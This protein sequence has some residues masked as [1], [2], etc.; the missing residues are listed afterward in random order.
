MEILVLLK[1][2]LH[3]EHFLKFRTLEE[4]FI[5]IYS[6]KKVFSRLTLKVVTK[7]I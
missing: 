7:I 5:Y 2:S 3:L 4:T 6:Y 1:L